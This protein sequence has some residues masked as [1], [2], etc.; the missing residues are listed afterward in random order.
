MRLLCMVLLAWALMHS[1]PAAAGFTVHCANEPARRCETFSE[2]VEF[3]TTLEP[4]RLVRVEADADM[5]AANIYS[6]DVFAL[7]FGGALLPTHI[8]TS[9]P[10]GEILH[11]EVYRFIAGIQRRNLFLGLQKAPF[12]F[13]QFDERWLARWE[14]LDAGYRDRPWMDPA[15][16]GA[17]LEQAS[18][19]ARESDPPP[20]MRNG[21]DFGL[22]TAIPR[23]F[24]VARRLLLGQRAQP[25]VRI[26][27]PVDE[28]VLHRLRYGTPAPPPQFDVWQA[29]VN[30]YELMPGTP[31][32]AGPGTGDPFAE[33]QYGAPRVLWTPPPRVAMPWWKRPVTFVLRTLRP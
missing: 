5:P 25:L 10:F 7:A 17:K 24:P 16:E 29:G 6:S 33:S 2:F 19:R 30:L 9:T 22:A 15:T 28:G 21:F 4:G 11:Q 26:D 12:D 32:I 14:V 31:S 13:M 20:P 8:D 1:P 18:M 3:V 27:A 23:M